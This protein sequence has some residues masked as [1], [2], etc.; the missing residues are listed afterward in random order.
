MQSLLVDS[1]FLSIL[2]RYRQIFRQIASRALVPGTAAPI[3]I[4]W[5]DVLLV[6]LGDVITFVAGGF[7]PPEPEKPS[8]LGLK[9]QSEDDKLLA[10]AQ[11]PRKCIHVF[12]RISCLTGCAVK[13]ITVPG[14]IA[15]ENASPAAKRLALRLTFASY[16]LAPQLKISDSWRD[17]G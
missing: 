7:C 4:C 14:V 17:T 3:I 13:W 10:A 11:L 1:L 8:L 16:V 5:V 2:F 12:I 9:A 15:S 6:K